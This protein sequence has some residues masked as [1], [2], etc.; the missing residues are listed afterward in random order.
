MAVYNQS[1]LSPDALYLQ[2]KSYDARADRKW[3]GDILSQGILN[4]T[5]YAITYSGGTLVL[6]YAAGIAYIFGGNI[7]DQG[8]YRQ[9][10]SAGSTITCPAADG[11]NPRIDTIILRIMDT[12][13]DGSGFSESRIECVP[14]TAT[15]GATLANLNGKNPLTSLGEASKSFIVLAYV[16][17]PAGA[18]VLTNTATNVRDA[19]TRAVVGAGSAISQI[20]LPYRKNTAKQVVNTVAET[21]LLNGE[22]TIGANVLGPNSILRLTAFGDWINNTG[23]PLIPPQFKLKL[24]GTS[25]FDTGQLG[26]IF[27]T[28]AN[29]FGWKLVALIQNLTATS[30]SCSFLLDGVM[31]NGV[32]ASAIAFI[33]GRGAY[34]AWVSA[35][36][37]G[38]VNGNAVATAAKDTTTALALVLSVINGSANALYDTTLTAALVEII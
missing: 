35:G 24:G 12:A 22:I 19:R 17:V 6:N 36:G 14:G 25:L 20:I 21:D 16:L 29:R 28:S 33:N 3:F 30:Q 10:I 4:A 13:A 31:G 11:T 8:M 38:L 18:T 37:F 27:S 34:N 2:P 26:A 9:F 1:L 32:G 23:G 15:A 7:A 5:D